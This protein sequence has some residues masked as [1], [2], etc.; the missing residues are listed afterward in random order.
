MKPF[1]FIMAPVETRSGYGDHSRDLIT[2]LIE[3]DM[4]DIKVKSVKW[5]NTPMT[6]LDKSREDHMEIE[7]RLYWEQ[8]LNVQP[9]VMIHIGVPN[10]F[11]NWGKFNVGITAGIETTQCSS[12]WLQGL[13]KM[14]MIIVPSEH[15]KNVFEK[16]IFE[17]MDEN[18]GQKVGELK[19]EVPIHVL[20]EGVNTDIF[21]PTKEKDQEVEEMMSKVKG[22]CFLMVGHWLKGE[23]GQ[24]RK[25]ISG[26][27]KVFCETFKN[28]SRK[29]SLVLKTSGADFSHIDRR[30]IR[31]KIQQVKGTISPQE[32][33][34]DVY[35]I[36]GDLSE[37]QMNHL[38]NHSKV[39]AH[40]SFT[41]GEG[42]GRP[43]AEASCSGKL[44]IAPKWSG[45]VDFLD[46]KFSVLLTGQLTPVHD[47]AVWE[48]VIEK[49]SS[50]F[51]VDYNVAATMI[52]NY[53]NNQKAY[54]S[55]GH[56]Q[57]KHIRENFSLESM[58]KDFKELVKSQFPK[59]AKQIDIKLPD[60]PSMELPT[61]RSS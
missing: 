24:D 39:K 12:E 14:D 44:V 7:K 22:D 32:G 57:S 25:D 15:S 49:G 29:P 28:Q 41:K 20:Y 46:P 18:T 56:K 33:L 37:K 50:W 6:G 17:R 1:M 53:Y 40:I 34:P 3:M 11:Q 23:M 4:F 16:T 35:F 43:L 52:R 10:E 47:S 51:T 30:E 19:C 9:D 45:H 21:K 13:N 2:S 31:S 54:K 27:I 55:R 60:L 42:Y 8:G 59:T 58:K 38:Y 48:N 61:L 36:H 26:L 5:G